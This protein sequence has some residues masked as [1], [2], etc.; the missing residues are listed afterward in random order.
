MA[1]AIE[2]PPASSASP[3]PLVDLEVPFHSE[4]YVPFHTDFVYSSSPAA[5][6]RKK[7]IFAND[8]S[9]EKC[10]YEVSTLI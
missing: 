1:A 4:V 6:M 3:L 5:K 10:T 2:T 8:V 9:L 7:Q